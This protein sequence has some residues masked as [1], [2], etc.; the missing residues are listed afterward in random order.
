MNLAAKMQ[1]IDFRARDR[2]RANIEKL[3]RIQVEKELELRVFYAVGDECGPLE[4]EFSFG[5]S[6][7]RNLAGAIETAQRWRSEKLIVHFQHVIRGEGTLLRLKN[8]VETKLRAEGWHKRGSW[9]RGAGDV[10]RFIVS[11]TA[12]EG[13]IPLLTEAEAVE[14]EQ[15]RLCELMDRFSGVL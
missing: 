13:G 10:A 8:D 15:Q 11:D 1:T 4:H 9:W 7:R 12:A 3:A 6:G 2:E 5:I 14:L